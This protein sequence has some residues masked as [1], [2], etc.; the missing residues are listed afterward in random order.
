MDA[1]RRV[2]ATFAQDSVHLPWHL[3]ASLGERKEAGVPTEVDT[4]RGEKRLD[5]WL[6]VGAL[7]G[8][9]DTLDE[10]LTPLGVTTDE[11]VAMLGET[12]QSLADRLG[13]EPE[14]H[15]CF[16]HWWKAGCE[17]ATD[18]RM[19]GPQLELLEAARHVMEGAAIELKSRARDRLVRLR[20]AHP[21]LQHQ[22]Q[23]ID[24]LLNTMP[25]G[26]LETYMIRTMVLELNVARVEG[27]LEGATPRERYASFVTLLRDEEQ[28][29]AIWREYPVLARLV[30][31]R[32]RS[33]VETRMELL[34]ALIAD[35]P[36]LVERGLLAQPPRHLEQVEFGQGDSHRGGRSVA[37]VVFDTGRVMFK[38]RPLAMDV[39][40]DGLLAWL[41][42]QRLSHPLR[43]IA[44]LDRGEY[45]WAEYVDTKQS[46][47]SAGAD[48]YAWRLG[49]LTGLLYLLHATDLHFE[50]ALASG[51][52]PVLVDLEAL[53]HT[54]KT[55]A[56]VKVGG[57]RDIAAEKLIRSVYSIGILPNP[58]LVRDEEQGMLS[59]DISV[60]AGRGGQ[61]SLQPAPT[62]EDV[63]TDTMHMVSRRV[64]MGA[65][66]NHPTAVDGTAFDLISRSD[67]FLDGFRQA[68]RT[69][70]AHRD[71]LLAPHGP[72]A[73]FTTTRS[74][75]IAR[76][77]FVYSRLLQEST[78][79]DFL[80][81]G[82]DRERSLARLCSGHKDVEHRLQ[83]VQNEA[84][85]LWR[86]DVPTFTVDCD[87]GAVRAGLTGEVIGYCALAPIADVAERA[88][89][90]GS[91]DYA[92]QEWVV[93]SS[94][95]TTIIGEGGAHWPN[96]RR[97]RQAKGVTADEFAEGAAQVARRLTDL[98]LRDGDG[99]G[100]VGL[101]LVEEKFWRLTP[102]PVS[103]Y[104]GIAGIAHALD[105]VATVTGQTDFEEL[106]REAF[107]YLTLRTRLLT[108][109]LRETPHKPNEPDLPIGAFSDLGGVVYALAHA[110]VRHPGR[111]YAEAAHSLL[112]VI[113]AFVD[114]D[115]ILDVLGGVAGTILVALALER[116][117]PARGAL[118]LAER[119]ADRLLTTRQQVGSGAA[120]VTAM[121]DEAPLAGFSHGASGIAVALARLH[122]VRPALAYA[123]AVRD[124]VRY[125]EGVYDRVRG[126]WRDLRPADQGGGGAELI[127]WC[128]GAAGIGL[129]RHELVRLGVAADISD[130]LE[131][132]RHRAVLAT[133][134]TGLDRDPVSGMGTHCLCHGDVGNLLILQRIHCADRE[135][136][137]ADRLPAVWRTLLTEGQENGWVCGVPHGIETPGLMT[138]IAGI[139][140][141]LA[142]MAAPERVPDL[143]ALEPPIVPDMT[144]DA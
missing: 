37:T 103:T 125:E 3:A 87:T 13:A 118:A 114:K 95:A 113:E 130:E 29:L 115:S 83:M 25:F 135:P 47:D 36:D 99:V 120:W 128:H 82:L 74:R 60:V 53:L 65:E 11:L 78:H 18:D 41:N 98:A 126:N 101:D 32:L 6:E 5:M 26:E 109:E 79:P 97:S 50:N 88:S 35:L 39:A 110:E 80:R 31:G 94:L 112:P 77:T 8:D 136:E 54:D 122:E 142:R 40:F 12:S 34:E 57:D 85:E 1:A 111:G 140:W 52:H 69:L 100:W 117:S 72:V 116:V 107:D 119:C 127:A 23:V 44:V 49:A 61:M 137:V 90:L 131:R 55:S 28:A 139:A 102:A 67:L 7:A 133:F 56:V 30:T 24:R 104:S 2:G 121:G 106:A 123:E 17:A 38:P 70:Q 76:P 68:Y 71:E 134:G 91:A 92:F 93:R 4:V 86:G 27:R 84:A 22:D 46:T 62:W 138:G 43:R 45:G 48:R 10:R 129:A 33:W 51:E 64:E 16:V 124:S 143:L 59:M 63:S 20:D 81:D 105:A 58:L 42:D 15:R 19:V 14:W 144:R 96:W 89:Q 21:V 141:G 66:R 132:D 73:A 9:R 108:E 75:L